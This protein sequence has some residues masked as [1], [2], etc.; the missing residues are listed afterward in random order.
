MPRTSRDS[1]RHD[2]A[3]R[4]EVLAAFRRWAARL[5]A[6]HPEVVRV[7]CFG[8]YARG[9]YGPSSDLDVFVEV[10]ESPHARRLDRPADLP[11]PSEIPVGV[12]LFVYTTAEIS[13]LLSEDSPRLREILGQMVWA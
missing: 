5:R 8:S 1:V 6:T 13:S 2:A 3:P 7:G 4:D 12:E 11:D 9:D 10:S